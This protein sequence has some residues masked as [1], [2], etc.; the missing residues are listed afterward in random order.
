METRVLGG[1]V[2]NCVGCLS[3]VFLGHLAPVAQLARKESPAVT[4]FQDQQ[5]R[6]VNPVCPASILL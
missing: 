1:A 5:G 2:S 6:R 3:K 4:E